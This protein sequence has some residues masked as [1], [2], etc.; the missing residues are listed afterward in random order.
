NVK[1][2]HCVVAFWLRGLFLD[3]DCMTRFVELDDAITAGIDDRTR[4]NG[5]ALFAR[6][7]GPHTVQFAVKNIV[8]EDQGDSVSIQERVRNKK[9][10]CDAL[11]PRL[12]GV[13]DPEA[14][15]RAVSEQHAKHGKVLRRR[16][17]EDL[18]DFAKHQHG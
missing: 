12:L 6:K 1:S 11:W 8:A 3:R 7:G 14:Q 17:N 16:D 10:L 4:E 13:V 5:G 9:S 15:R 18:P 2:G